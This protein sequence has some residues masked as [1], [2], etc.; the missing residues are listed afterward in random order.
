MESK[1]AFLI[2]DAATG[3]ALGS[4]R[5]YDHHPDKKEIKIGYTFFSK[6]CWGKSINKNV[7]GL[8]IAHA[9]TFVDTIIFH[10]GASNF[11]SQIAMERLGALKIGTEEVAYFGE[12]S[13]LNHVYQISKP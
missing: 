10:V 4:S 8:M 2:M 13:R 1:G 3:K 11:R 5:F 9:L 6:A 7:K 12:A